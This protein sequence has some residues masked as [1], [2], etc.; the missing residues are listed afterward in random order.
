MSRNMFKHVLGQALFQIIVLTILIFWGEKFIPE[1]ADS[2]DQT[3]FASHP[4]WKWYNGVQGGTVCSGRYY[5]ISGD[6]DYHAVYQQTEIY[7]RHFTFIFNAFVM[8]Q[9]FN[10]LNCRKIKD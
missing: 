8:M 1:Y 2:Y 5:T 3:Q 9:I 4:S 6:E 10:F 7:S